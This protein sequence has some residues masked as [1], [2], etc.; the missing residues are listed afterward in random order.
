MALSELLILSYAQGSGSDTAASGAGPATAVTG[1]SATNGAGNIV[2]LDGSPDL[3]GVSVNDVIWA[4]SATTNRHLSR[5]TAVDDGADTVTTEELLVL[6]GG[7]S[8]AIG[9]ERQT[10]EN[11]TG[12]FD[13]EDWHG[14]WAIEF[15]GDSGTGLYT[16]NTR[17]NVPDPGS[18]AD[19]FLTLRAKPGFTQMPEIDHPS[20]TNERAI[21]FGVTGFRI[22]FKDMRLTTA[23]NGSSASMLYTNSSNGI[24]LIDGCDIEGESAGLP[25]APLIHYN[26][27]GTSIVRMTNSKVY[28]VCDECMSLSG[29]RAT[30]YIAGNWFDGAEDAGVALSAASSFTSQTILSNL[31]TNITAG[32]GLLIT[33]NG[34]AS[35]A[36][37]QGN[38]FYNCDDGAEIV[39]TWTNS[40]LVVFNNIFMDN[41]NY[42]INA[43][44]ATIGESVWADYNAYRTN[45]VGEVNNAERGSN[46][47]TLTVDPFTNPGADDFTINT[48]AGGGAALRDVAYPTEIL[49]NSNMTAL[50]LNIGLDQAEAGGGGGGVVKLAGQSGGLVG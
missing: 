49:L 12:Q 40:N 48:T 3:S 20:A 18:V 13:W 32:P 31:F 39:G 33:G 26:T 22:S 44:T 27:S 19:G 38:I 16:M 21:E 15:D 50:D 41:S 35:V 42:G 17:M 6:G 30:G 25:S 28:G 24:L 1:S 34:S 8:W 43:T 14:G 29:G 23:S 2:N 46:E 7:V 9:G 37:I 45:G 11:D 36:T 10:F 4:N 5:I 47:I